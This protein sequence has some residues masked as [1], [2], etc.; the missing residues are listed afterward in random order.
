MET[1]AIDIGNTLTKIHFFENNEWIK[2]SIFSNE[3]EK[4]IYET[5]KSINSEKTIIS[6]VSKFGDELAKSLTNSLILNHKTKLPFKIK[7]KTPKTLGIDRIALTAGAHHFFPNQ[8]CLII[9]LGTCITYDFLNSKNEYLG[10]AI[11][12]GMAIRLQSL[13]NYT[14]KLPL[15]KLDSII[16]NKVNLI[17]EST[18]ESIA[19]GIFYGIFAELN[20]MINKYQENYKDLT[21]LMTG[22]DSDFFALHLKNKIFANSNLQAIGLNHILNY[23]AH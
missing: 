11:S 12:P 22:G 15:I 9:D 13:N 5:I 2:K 17:G 20:G 19:S 7:Y 23:N 21:V 10:G 14:S 6:S 18:E 8:N 4:A 1:I 3:E 16:N